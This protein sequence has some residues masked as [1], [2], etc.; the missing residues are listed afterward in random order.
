MNKESCTECRSEPMIVPLKDGRRMCE[1]CLE[2]WIQDEW[3]DCGGGWD[4]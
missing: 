4:L 2:I 1:D 3:E